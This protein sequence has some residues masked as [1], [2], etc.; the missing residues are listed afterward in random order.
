[1]NA[2]LQAL[3]GRLDTHDSARLSLFKNN[4]DYFADVMKK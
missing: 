2:K 1:M 4:P 3:F